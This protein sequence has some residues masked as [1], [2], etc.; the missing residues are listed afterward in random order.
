MKNESFHMP[1]WYAFT[2][3]IRH[4]KRV[5]E[6]IERAGIESYLPLRR[7]LNQWKDRKKWVE[8]PLFPSYI[9]TKIPYSR[10]FDVLKIDSVVNIVGFSNTPSPVRPDE[11]EAIKS[12]LDSK[13]PYDIHVGLSAG[14]R[15]RIC[16]GPLNGLEARIA[17]VRGGKRIVFNISTL[18][19]SL[20]LDSA[21]FDIK[22]LDDA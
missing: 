14:R 11:I 20:I 21:E 9:F 18:G 3:R 12:L 5:N 1:Q 4:E 6:D 17:Q 22:L 8:T 10:R 2:T 19:K 15:V 13:T 7:S 16:S